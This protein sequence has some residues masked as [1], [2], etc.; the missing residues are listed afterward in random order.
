MA[1][2]SVDITGHRVDPPAWGG[3]GTPV[4]IST[5]PNLR[6]IHVLAGDVLASLGKRRDVGGRGRNESEDVRLA[7]AWLSAHRVSDLV[8]LDA[9]RLMPRILHSLTKLAASAGVDLWLLHRPPVT[10]DVH[11]A[12]ARRSDEPATV[13][14]VPRPAAIV[15]D[16]ATADP[17]GPEAP[18]HDLHSFVEA[19]RTT[20]SDEDAAIVL[21]NY[22][23]AA[24]SATRRMESETNA[25][26]A[27]TDEIVRLLRS[28][29]RDGELV[30]R[31][32]GIQLAAWHCDL[33]VSVDLPQL[34]N[35]EER[36]RVSI[37]QAASVL[38]SYRQPYRAVTWQLAAHNIGL[39]DAAT[40]P[41]HAAAADGSTIATSAGDVTVEPTLRPAVRA[42]RALRADASPD[43]PLLNLSEK[44]LGYALTDAAL[45]LGVPAHGRLAERRSLAPHTWL[46]KLGIT[47][48][49]LP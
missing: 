40:I 42:Q 7:A 46:R 16:A 13:D 29:P 36:P 1:V 5:R 30:S 2:R 12:L 47:I 17:D 14:S 3:D 37:K 15:A 26:D 34:R 19:V 44:T 20:L 33:H 43:E 22:D 9:Q 23:A 35:S 38:L 10:D 27:V 24:E 45:D 6:R 41:I 48:R 4:W 21:D 8:V 28:A 39:A 31:L 18:D 11:R 32:R 49:P 25:S